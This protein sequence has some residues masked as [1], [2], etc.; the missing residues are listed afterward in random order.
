MTRKRSGLRGKS[1]ES[2]VLARRKKGSKEKYP[3][4]KKRRKKTKDKSLEKGSKSSEQSRSKE[5]SSDMSNEK[6]EKRSEDRIVD[7]IEE[8]KREEFP[9]N[10]RKT[11][12]DKP[13]EPVKARRK[14]DIEKA[15]AEEEAVKKDEEKLPFKMASLELQERK[16]EDIYRQGIPPNAIEKTAIDVPSN[17]VYANPTQPDWCIPGGI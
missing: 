16:L 17:G 6:D 1:A 11:D 12:D 7:K 10:T 13:L 9:K 3:Q 2:D 5:K 15:S 8:E 4:T 14:S